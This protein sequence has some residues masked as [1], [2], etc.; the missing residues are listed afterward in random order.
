MDEIDETQ[1]FIYLKNL[2]T[3]DFLESA[4]TTK[5]VIEKFDDHFILNELD[6]LGNPVSGSK[7]RKFMNHVLDGLIRN[8]HFG[9][10]TTGR[11]I[12][13]GETERRFEFNKLTPK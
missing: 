9:K 10:T 5:Y 12:S 13:H 11:R 8:K 4:N 6:S 2:K 7:K 1:E 3:G